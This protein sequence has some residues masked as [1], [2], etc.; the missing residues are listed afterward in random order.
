MNVRDFCQ[1]YNLGI[2][3][4]WITRKYA[5]QDLDLLSWFDLVRSDLSSI[6]TALTQAVLTE[7]E[8]NTRSALVVYQATVVDD[9]KVATNPKGKRGNIEK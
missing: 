3:A 2:D 6:P 8:R 7:K 5:N 1:K 4:S 9:D